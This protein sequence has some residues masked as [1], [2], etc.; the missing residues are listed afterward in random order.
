[1]IGRLGRLD[2]EPGVYVYVGSAFG[3]GGL[4]ARIRHHSWVTERPHWHVDFL[5]A[6]CPL[7]E[8]WFSD[9]P[10]R[11]EHAWASAVARMPGA[12]I[13]MPRFGSSDCGCAAHLFWFPNRRAFAESERKPG[14]MQRCCILG[15]TA[16]PD[17]SRSA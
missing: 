10:A 16:P 7:V 5:R 1:M 6:I 15:T 14:A 3:P 8:V 11:E 13:P 17:V 9:A 4:A 2:V 12:V